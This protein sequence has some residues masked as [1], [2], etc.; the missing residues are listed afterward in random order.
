MANAA[1]VVAPAPKPSQQKLLSLDV[2]Q[3]KSLRD[4]T[5]DFSLTPLTAIMGGNCSGK[6]TVLQALACAHRPPNPGDPDYKFAQ[7][8]RPN[9]DALWQGSK[10]SVSYSQR[11]GSVE[12]P[13]LK[14]EY[15]KA[16]DRWSPRYQKRPERYTRFVGIGESVPDVDALNLNSMIHYQKAENADGVGLAVREVAG[17]VLNRI[18]N[19]LYKVTYNYS[20]K[21]SIGVKCGDVTYSGLSMSSGEQRVFRILDAVFRAPKSSLILVD[22]IDLFLHQDALQRLLS[23]LK[24]H[25]AEKKKQLVFTTHFPPVAQMY[26]EMC[27]YTL[28]YSTTKTVVWRGYSYE[29]MRHITGEQQRPI[30]CYVE[31]DVAEQ[32]VARVATELGIRKFVVFGH[33]G[34][35]AN[36][37]SLAAG[38]RLSAANVDNAIAILDGDVHGTWNARMERIKSIWSG[39]QPVHDQ[40]RAD[41]IRMILT[42][43]PIRNAAGLL[44][45]PEQVLHQ[46][47]HGLAV[48][49]IPADRKELHGLALGVVNVP[50]KHGFVNQIIEH[51]GESREIALSKIVELASTSTRWRYY[52]RLVRKWLE[53]QKQKLGL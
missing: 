22:E 12:H 39:D 25:C 5:L 23:K 35:A 10:F 19:T 2:V 4:I 36:A 17:Q 47:L 3:L 30:S 13:N 14:Q 24:A 38:L 7:F 26:D 49:N 9:T 16:Q 46:M 34:P 41:L 8:F 33:Y 53:V 6:T 1:L 52:T 28:N 32:I 18:Y 50:D 27:I 45:S 11:L 44:L 40:E 37:F 48:A 21:L 43:T 42:L 51:T 29:A 15:S 20:G 31:D